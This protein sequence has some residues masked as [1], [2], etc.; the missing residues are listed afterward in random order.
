[1]DSNELCIQSLVVERQRDP[2]IVEDCRVLA[3][4]CNIPISEW[5]FTERGADLAAL[6][7]PLRGSI[8]RPL[9]LRHD[10]VE[11]GVVQ[12]VGHNQ[13]A[14]INEPIDLC[15]GQHQWKYA[16]PDRCRQ[17]FGGDSPRPAGTFSGYTQ[18]LCVVPEP[19][20]VPLA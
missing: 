12:H 13:V 18:G 7:Q 8:E 16:A 14:L 15:I 6:E 1:M 11:I 20:A 4:D 3:K 17:R 19:N 5:Q 2:E 10:R 9:V